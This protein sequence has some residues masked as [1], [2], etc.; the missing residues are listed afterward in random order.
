MF[1]LVEFIAEVTLLV[2]EPLRYG[3]N[4]LVKVRRIEQKENP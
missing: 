1:G 4:V 3:T 2:S